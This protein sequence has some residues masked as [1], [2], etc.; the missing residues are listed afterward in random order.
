MPSQISRV[1]RQIHPRI[2]ESA[3][4]ES[5]AGMHGN[6]N[7]ERSRFKNG[8]VSHGSRVVS[9]STAESV[10]HQVRMPAAPLGRRVINNLE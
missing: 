6:L 1:R 5:L 3:I 2:F 8:N 9:A 7:T 4:T 10:V